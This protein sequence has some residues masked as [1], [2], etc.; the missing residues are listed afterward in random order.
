MGR[1]SILIGCPVYQ[2]PPFLKEFL[3]SLKN[4]NMEGFRGDFLFI[5]DNKVEESK[6]LLKDFFMNGSKVK[7]IESI[8][9]DKYVC[10][11]KT[12]N[13]NDKLIWKVAGFKNAIIS[14]ARDNNYDYLFLID[15]DILLYPETIHHLIKQDKDIISEIFWTKWRPKSIELPQVWMYDQYKMY[16]PPPDTNL[17]NAEIY[18]RLMEF[19][20]K[21]KVPGVYKVGGLGACTLISKKAMDGG[22]SF[23]RIPNISL[24]GEDRHFCIR[25]AVLGFE[26]YVDTHYPGYHIYRDSDLM[27]IDEFKKKC[28]YS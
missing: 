28:G 13:W 8:N 19:I 24:W 16:E 1:L 21:L 27:G 23:S 11:E 18:L 25:A 20:H 7:I 3:R 12:H 17:S 22:V 10:N 14:H 9:K 5:D 26:L 4:I 6:K 2:K 15:S